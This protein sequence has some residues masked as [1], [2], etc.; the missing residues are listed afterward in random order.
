ML[1]TIGYVQ[2]PRRRLC[3]VFQRKIKNNCKL[4]WFRHLLWQS[5]RKWGA[6]ILQCWR[7]PRV[8]KFTNTWGDNDAILSMV[9]A[10]AILWASTHMQRDI[11]SPPNVVSA[12]YPPNTQSPANNPGKFFRC[13]HFNNNN[14]NNNNMKFIKHHNAVRRLQRSLLVYTKFPYNTEVPFISFLGYAKST[15]CVQCL[16][17][18][19]KWY[20]KHCSQR[21]AVKIDPT[22]LHHNIDNCILQANK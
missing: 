19:D 5:V 18:G 14:N 7:N 1:K 13:L 2:W 4:S 8:A 17:N 11:L 6:L 21:L 10:V 3:T 22:N 12:I 16:Q 9:V 15:P 20:L